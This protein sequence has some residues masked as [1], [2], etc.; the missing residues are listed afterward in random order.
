ME[1]KTYQQVKEIEEAAKLQKLISDER[2]KNEELQRKIDSLTRMMCAE[3][4]DEI[5]R[6]GM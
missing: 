3:C 1:S 2:E 5:R 6:R 4:F